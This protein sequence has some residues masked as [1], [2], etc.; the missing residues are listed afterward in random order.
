MWMRNSR[1]YVYIYIYI[2]VCM[3]VVEHMYSFSLRCVIVDRVLE[4]FLLN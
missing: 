2:F 1:I 3:S 4:V